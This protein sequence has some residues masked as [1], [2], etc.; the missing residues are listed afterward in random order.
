MAS[1]EVSGFDYLLIFLKKILFIYFERV[2]GGK[3]QCVVA[4]C[5]PPTGDLVSNPGMYTDWKSSGDPLVHRPALNLLRQPSQG[6][7]FTN[8][9]VQDLCK[10]EK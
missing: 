3:H 2:K 6:S 7:L 4:S 8:I 10:E 5:M 1:L 9:L